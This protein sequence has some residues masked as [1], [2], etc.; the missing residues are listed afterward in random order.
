MFN[1]QPKDLMNETDILLKLYEM[2]SA[3]G[4]CSAFDAPA[5]VAKLIN[6]LDTSSEAYE[7][8]VADLLALGACI[9]T[10]LE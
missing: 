1:T 2:E 3:G 7:Q 9:L 4:A 5:L 6:S 10:M 8:Q